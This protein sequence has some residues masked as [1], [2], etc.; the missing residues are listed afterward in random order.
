MKKVTIDSLAE[1][2]SKE[3]LNYS[4]VTTEKVKTA[5]KEAG[6]RVK[7]EIQANAPKDTGKY[8]SSWTVKNTRETSNSLEVTVHSRD[9]YQLA[10]LIE[11]G[12]AK[13]NGGR[14]KA[15]EHIKPAEEIGLEQY[16]KDIEEAIRNG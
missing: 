10:H 4:E 7:K 2:I 16:E 8:S 11:F 5:V 3:L 9:R 6:N 1:T 14:T 13:R 12:H 15:I